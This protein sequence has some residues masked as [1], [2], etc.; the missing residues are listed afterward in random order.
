MK[1]KK[2][3][4]PPKKH[5]HAICLDIFE[6]NNLH[7]SQLCALLKIVFEDKYLTTY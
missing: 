1:I 5:P 6:N 3:N 2:F 4:G 7:Y